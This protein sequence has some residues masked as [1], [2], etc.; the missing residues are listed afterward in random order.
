M[1]FYDSGEL[2]DSGVLYDSVPSSQPTRKK[3]A[4]VRLGLKDL[5]REQKISQAT[6]IKTA[7]TGNANFP[8]TD[9][10]LTAY[11]TLITTAQSKLN[12]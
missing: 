9:P 8:S 11:G 5:T 7:L 4:K 12:T 6:T 10:T 1:A 3:M 2:Y